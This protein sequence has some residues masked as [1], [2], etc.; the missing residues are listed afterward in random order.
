MALKIFTGAKPFLKANI[1][2]FGITDMDLLSS[3][4][5]FLTKF[6]AFDYLAYATTMISLIQMITQILDRHKGE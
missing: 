4:G 2:H 5:F 1:K 3:I 6:F